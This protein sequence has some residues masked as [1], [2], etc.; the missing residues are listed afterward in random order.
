VVWFKLLYAMHKLLK[1]FER[2]HSELSIQ[3]KQCTVTQIFGQG[4]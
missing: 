1:R 4:K 3:A 2:A